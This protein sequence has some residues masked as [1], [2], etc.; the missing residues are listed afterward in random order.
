MVKNGAVS[1]LSVPTATIDTS[2]QGE[3]YRQTEDLAMM[4]RL[5]S[6]AMKNAACDL[7]SRDGVGGAV[8][9]LCA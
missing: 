8:A 1:F 2:C 6:Y 4:S 5:E 9:K 7:T 3:R